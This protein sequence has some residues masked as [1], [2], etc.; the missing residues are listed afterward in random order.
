M[1]AEARPISLTGI[2]NHEI[3]RE[4]GIQTLINLPAV[5]ENFQVSLQ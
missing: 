4:A 2:G 5:G 1:R 3:L